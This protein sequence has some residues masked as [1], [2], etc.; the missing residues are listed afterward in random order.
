M[1]DIK[2]S[3]RVKMKAIAINHRAMS[4]VADNYR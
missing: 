3:S 4:K 2:K 1:L